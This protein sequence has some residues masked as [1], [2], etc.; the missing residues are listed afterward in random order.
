MNAG[1]RNFAPV[2]PCQDGG[3]PCAQGRNCGGLAHLVDEVVNVL[4]G[5]HLASYEA[6]QAAGYRS[7][8]SKRT[9]ER[10]VNDPKNANKTHSEQSLVPT[11]QRR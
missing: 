8:P 4:N 6:C 5:S 1:G 10:C 2:L 11:P 9:L 7:L 3:S